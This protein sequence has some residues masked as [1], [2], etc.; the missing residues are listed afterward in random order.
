MAQQKVVE[1]CGLMDV[2][3]KVISYTNFHKIFMIS[4]IT[5]FLAQDHPS[6]CESSPQVWIAPV[7]AIDPATGLHIWWY[8]LWMQ[9]APGISLNQLSY[10]TRRAFVQNTVMDLLQVSHSVRG[11]SVEH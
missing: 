5:L 9:R 7:N 1:E 4:I 2:T 6:P 11:I 10:V 8:G 3:I